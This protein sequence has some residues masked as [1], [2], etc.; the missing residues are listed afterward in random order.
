MKRSVLAVAAVTGALHLALAGRYDIFRNE[1]YFIDCGRHVDFGYVDQ[2]PLVPL[3][4]AATQFFGENIGL[5]RL[6]AVIAAAALP[7]I[8][9]ALAR[10]FGGSAMAEFLA[11]AATALAPPLAG[12]TTT[13]T[14]STFEPLAW[15]MT[16]YFLARAIGREERRALIW[17]GV[18]AGV[19]M[20]AKYGVAMW[21]IGLAAGLAATQARRVFLW[22]QAWIAAAIAII[23]AAPSLVW[24]M[25]HGWPFFSAV[26]QPQV[27]GRDY[28]GTPLAFAE[29]Q[30]LLMNPLLFPLWAA[31]LIA[32][33]LADR[34]KGARFLLI[35]A[36][37]AAVIDY[38]G[39]GKDY[40][41]FPVY[42]TLMAMAPQ[43]SKASARRRRRRG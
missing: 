42:P 27:A 17:A 36:A 43:P 3:V 37:L 24:Q 22:R 6:P 21:L 18:T 38:G 7:L 4:A 34:L 23:F 9:A 41:L 28:L 32:P 30:I 25:L 8:A 2:P 1:L 29:W 14:T 12:F 16:A 19:A 33:F 15:T 39:G 5:L 13:L 31:G 40:Y 10:E 26:F 35:A 20:E 11:A